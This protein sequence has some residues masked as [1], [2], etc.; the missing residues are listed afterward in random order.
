MAKTT[1]PRL[2]LTRWSAGTDTIARTDFDGDHA[3]LEAVVMMYAQGTLAARPAA[4]TEGRIYTVVG[5]ATASNNGRQYYDTGSTWVTNSYLVDALI[6]PSVVGNNGLLV[7]GVSGQT[8]DIFKVANN[9]GTNLF[10]VSAS[11]AITNQTS[12]GTTAGYYLGLT[13]SHIAAGHF[14]SVDVNKPVL[15][16]R[17]KASQVSSVLLVQ[18]SS[19]ATIFSVGAGGGVYTPANISAA[20]VAAT[21]SVQGASLISTASATL[22]NAA[23]SPVATSNTPLVVTGVASQTANMAEFRDSANAVMS[24]VSPNGAFAT[25]NRVVIGNGAGATTDQY[26]TT[27]PALLAYGAHLDASTPIAKLV[28][29]ASQTGHIFQTTNSVND[30]KYWINTSG[31]S[32][33]E[34]VMSAT[35][36]YLG[37][38]N[39][40]PT[41]LFGTSYTPKLEVSTG[42]STESFTDSVILRHS[43][44]SSNAVVRSVG[45][46]FKLSTEANLTESNKS[47]G[48]YVSS[49]A[50][51]GASPSLLFS[52]GSIEAGR[53]DSG[54]NLNLAG[55]LVLPGTKNVSMGSAYGN[56]INLYGSTHQI[57]AQTSSLY[58]RAD[59]FAWFAGGVHNDALFNAGGGTVLATLTSG[60]D[61]RFT[62]GK[63]SVQ[64]Y[65]AQQD[66]TPPILIGYNSGTHLQINWNSINAYIGSDHTND[67]GG[68]FLNSAGT[69]GEVILG[70]ST[71]KVR[72][73]SRTLWVGGNRVY[74]GGSTWNAQGGSPVENDWWFDHTNNQIKVLNAANQW[75][76]VGDDDWAP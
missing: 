18:N 37:S 59:N 39:G 36:G 62:T 38:S 31:N 46:L 53:F 74:W 40:Q 65:G 47:A 67:K 57:G 13:S 73:D 45:M 68:L 44:A 6:E 9:S 51:S 16:A 49:S 27:T 56:K 58:H 60:A 25:N 55:N 20:S 22:K 50:A 33:Q 12:P 29:G 19:G 43:G 2:S 71:T 41:T 1:S 54:L 11:G 70:A 42:T 48:I 26:N 30:V 52:V 5:D 69:G 21:A 15:V 24:R 35:A 28:A 4:G 23:I 63:I 64:D 32:G 17:A 61:R 8:A 10:S 66:T 34:G 76:I 72:L 14:Y 3:D 75:K 7:R